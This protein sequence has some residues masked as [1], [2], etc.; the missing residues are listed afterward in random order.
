MKITVIGAGAIGGWLAARLANVPGV[1]MSAIARGAT[2]EALHAR[3][4]TLVSEGRTSLISAR[5]HHFIPQR[6]PAPPFMMTLKML[7]SLPRS[8][9]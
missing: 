9:N 7:K 8:L 3:G 2:L 6:P 4:I 1:Q 5:E